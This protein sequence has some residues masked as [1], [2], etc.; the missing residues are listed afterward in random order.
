MNLEANELEALKRLKAILHQQKNFVDFWVYGSKVR[1]QSTAESDID[2]MIIVE[3]Y[4]HDFQSMIDDI[5]FELNLE[6]DCFI[7]A[8]IFSRDELEN[9]PMS[10]SPLYKTAV[11][12]GVRI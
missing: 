9:G 6:Y 1:G 7:S 12:E 2:V 4:S 8:T 5:I 10:E 3:E 11:K